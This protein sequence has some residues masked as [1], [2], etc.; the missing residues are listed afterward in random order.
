MKDP[1]YR[2][3]YLNKRYAEDSEFRERRKR[4]SRDYRR[5]KYATDPKWRAKESARCT[6]ASRNARLMRKYGVTV[7]QYDAA[8]FAQRGACACC[9]KKLGRVVRV[10]NLE[11]VGIGLLCTGC[12]KQVATLRHVRQHADAFEAYFKKWGM[13]V[14]LGRFYE[15]MRGMGWTPAQHQAGG[16]AT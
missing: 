5:H 15:V 6:R 7:D 2:K 8:L 16:H 13:A 1:E 3:K 12:F 10:D 14:Q 9:D 4:C 11:R